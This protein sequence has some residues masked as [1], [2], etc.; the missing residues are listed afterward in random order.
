MN[1]TSRL[2]QDSSGLQGHRVSEE[3]PIEIWMKPLKDGSKV[4]G[5][6]NREQGTLKVTLQLRDI[7]IAGTAAV[8]DLWQR[9]DL[10]LFSGSFSAAVG[11]HQMMLLKIR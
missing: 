4:V 6:F 11:E 3:G 1:S 9:K 8:R 7:G 10:G 5:L 2:T